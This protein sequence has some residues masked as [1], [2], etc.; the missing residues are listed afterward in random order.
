MRKRLHGGHH[1]GRVVV[2]P[3]PAPLYLQVPYRVPADPFD[4]PLD[5]D[6]IMLGIDTY[7]LA[8]VVPSDHGPHVREY[9]C[10]YSQPWK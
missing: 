6:E 1:D 9:F 7:E 3:D 8:E 10:R 5:P 2:V 4:V